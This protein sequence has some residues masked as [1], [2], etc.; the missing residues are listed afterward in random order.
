ML[1]T[2]RSYS[3]DLKIRK[4]TAGQTVK[5]EGLT[6]ISTLE[7][8]VETAGL[9]TGNAGLVV[10]FSSDNSVIPTE[11]VEIEKVVIPATGTLAVTLLP[12]I[13]TGS[14]RVHNDTDNADWTEG[15][16]ADAAT[17]YALN[18]TNGILT[19]GLLGAGDSFTVT[20]RRKLSNT[21]SQ[22]LYGDV[23]PGLD[24]NQKNGEVSVMKGQGEIYTDRWDSSADWSAATEAFA[25]AN[26]MLIPAAGAGSA[27]KA[28][29]I[30]SKPTASDPF[31]GIAFN[32]G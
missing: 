12:N 24:F 6:L 13:V 2:A 32:L 23:R 1:D 28:G 18:V 29:R 19:V 20:Y 8:G 7:S 27:P 31:I 11:K 17:K 16:V 10:G 21:E 15:T 25:G 30:V 3:S 9:S 14:V 26:G 5:E 22:A 4:V